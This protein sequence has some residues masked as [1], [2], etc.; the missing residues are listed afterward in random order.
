MRVDLSDLNERVY[1]DTNLFIYAMDTHDARKHQIAKQLLD[2]VLRKK[3]GC[4]SAQVLSEWRNVM[5]RKY[6]TKVSADFRSGFLVWLAAK[7]PLP[8]TGDLICRSELLMAS[9][10]FSAY[11]SMH[12]QAALD[13]GCRFFLSEDM[14]DGLVVEKGMEIVNPFT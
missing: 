9:Y 7:N 10:C 4:Y 13:M 2:T 12:I 6:A 3:L 1:L 8:V 14:Q 5:V 11:D